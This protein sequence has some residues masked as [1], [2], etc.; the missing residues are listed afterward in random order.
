[1]SS[2]CNSLRCRV[3]TMLFLI[4]ITLYVAVEL[5]LFTSDQYVFYRAVTEQGLPY[6]TRTERHKY[7]NLS[8]EDQIKLKLAQKK[9][10]LLELT[11]N[12]GRMV[13]G[14]ITTIIVGHISDVY[15]RRVALGILMIG[16]IF[17][18]GITSIIIFLEWNV[19]LIIVAGLFEAIFGGG[20]LCIFAIV[21]TIIFDVTQVTIDNNTTNNNEHSFKEK[22]SNDQLLWILITVFDCV[23]SLSASLSTP[24]SGTIIYRYGFK[25]AVITFVALFIPSLILILFLPETN[26]NRKLPFKNSPKNT[27][28]TDSSN[29]IVSDDVY[30]IIIVLNSKWWDRLMRYCSVLKYLDA[31]VIILGFI[32]LLGSITT[33]TDLQ[34]LAVYLMGTPFLWNPQQVGIYVGLTDF[35][36]SILSVTFTVIMVKIMAKSRSD[37]TE[38]SNDKYYLNNTKGKSRKYM[39]QLKWLIVI[40]AACLVLMIINKILIAYAYRYDTK[41]ASL[42]VYIA[43]VPK[44]VRNMGLAVVHIMFTIVTPP[45]KQGI[46]QCVGEFIARIGLAISLTALPAIYLSTVTTFP[47][48][49]FI[50]VAVLIFISL[51]LDLLLFIYNDPT[52]SQA[53]EGFNEIHK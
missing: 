44:L 22:K 46:I 25:A 12:A 28:V 30:K 3:V 13:I 42:I 29:S 19:W 24:L 34:Y 45:D 52:K 37:N 47:E 21:S 50:V 33:L 41:E 40:L 36:S 39:P 20:L 2:S 27:K 11:G 16:E 8:D 51:V 48:A 4:A 23:S 9:A 53:I 38:N 49:V 10:A 43:A 17:H 18:I 35:V 1:M 6:L 26:S 15:G 14:L 32:I 7:K 5:C 31:F